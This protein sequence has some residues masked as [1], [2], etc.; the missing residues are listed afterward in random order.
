MSNRPVVGIV[1][2]GGWLGGA[3]AAQALAAGVIDETSLIISS[4]TPRADRLSQWP[5]VTWTS[6][7]EEL[8]RRA[9][10]VILSVRPDQFHDLALDL[11]GRL[12]VSVMA[13]VPMAT[14]Q[15]RLGTARV[16]R[17]MPNAAAEIG[18][19]YTPWLVSA[20]V[21]DEDRVF[22]RALFEC[23]GQSDEI[24]TEDQL[25]Y[26]TG[27]SG[28]GPAF[29][30]LLAQAMLAHAETR[31]LP[32]QVALRATIGIVSS[33]SRLLASAD[34]SPAQTV[35][36]FVDYDGTTAAALR[37]MM[38]AGFVEAVHAGLT[39]AEKA[40]AAMA[41]AAEMRPDS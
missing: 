9:D 24:D 18:M 27:L 40:A 28:S 20:G 25:D 32:P 15:A 33:A 31:G 30:A 36:T 23:C 17:S 26:L 37:E 39:A 4:R 12:A 13:G 19:S 21:T 14:L 34:A 10:V 5:A 38:R 41:A 6:D 3:I 11:D 7:N 35:R 1:G 29:P 8:I 16:I 22:A 2:G